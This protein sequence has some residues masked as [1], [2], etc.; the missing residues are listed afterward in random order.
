MERPRSPPS[1]PMGL[2][3]SDGG[4]NREWSPVPASCA[5]R[6]PRSR[7]GDQEHRGTSAGR[8]VGRRTRLAPQPITRPRPTPIPARDLGPAVR[9]AGGR[10]GDPQNCDLARLPLQPRVPPPT[11][12]FRPSVGYPRCPLAHHRRP[13][14]SGPATVCASWP[15]PQGRRG[16]ARW[17]GPGAR[18]PWR[19]PR[20]SRPCPTGRSAS[21]DPLPSCAAGLQI[22]HI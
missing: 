5:E 2:W 6:W 15:Q 20:A 13:R 8:S 17:R 4:S 19:S 10:R 14:Y 22:W 12:S 1:Q 16:M 9:A 7:R 3:P 11:P 21:L 18:I